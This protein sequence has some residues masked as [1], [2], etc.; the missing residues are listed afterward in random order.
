M[1]WMIRTLCET[2]CQGCVIRV[3]QKAWCQTYSNDVFTKGHPMCAHASSISAWWWY[4][5]QD[6]SFYECCDTFVKHVTKIHIPDTNPHLSH[7][8]FQNFRHLV[9]HFSVYSP[10]YYHPEISLI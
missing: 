10:R 5:C 1:D 8:L 4:Y 2:F 9:R 3:K 6:C 7:L